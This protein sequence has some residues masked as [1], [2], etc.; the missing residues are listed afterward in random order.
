MGAS[1]GKARVATAA[2]EELGLK[3]YDYTEVP[4]RGFSG[5]PDLM[6]IN[7]DRVPLL[8]ERWRL[9]PARIDERLVERAAGIAGDPP[10]RY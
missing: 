4:E 5:Q 1:V 2:E 9:D 7:V 8:A 10:P 3:C 6:A